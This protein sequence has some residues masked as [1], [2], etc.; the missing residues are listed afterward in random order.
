MRQ[1]AS[2]LAMALAMGL[3]AAALPWATNP[4]VAEPGASPLSAPARPARAKPATQP[5]AG[6]A[7]TAT[8]IRVE[9]NGAETRF[10]MDSDGEAQPTIFL[11]A[12]PPRVIIDIP[13]FEFRIPAAPGKAAPD[14]TAKERR[15][16]I[17]AFRYGL[18][19]PGQARIVI[20]V[21][22]P[23][24]VTR[25]EL[26]KPA[27]GQRIYT[28]TVGLMPTDDATFRSSVSEERAPPT[29]AD[30]RGEAKLKPGLAHELDVV[31]PPKSRPVIVIDAGHGGLDPGAVGVG[32]VLEKSIVLQVA[33]RLRATLAATRRYDVVMTRAT[34]IFVPLDQ[35]V[36]ISTAAAA[37]LF[38]SLHADSIGPVGE[39]IAV[40]G[41]TVYT[42]S[43]RASD[44]EARRLAEKENAVD[45]LAGV[46]AQEADE[47]DQVKDILIDLLRR[48]TANFSSDFRTMLVGELR[49]KIAMARDPNRSAAFK[50]LRQTRTP[51]V[52]IELGYMSHAQDQALMA[53]PEWQQMVAASIATSVDSYFSRRVVVGDKP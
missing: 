39:A 42:L 23:V 46:K 34:D 18:F 35:R 40:R 9:T 12:N 19:G 47:R 50:V 43:E 11:V 1:S 14:H 38:I 45:L 31:A 4:A 5:S 44:E 6:L 27:G 22:G 52:L 36:A 3:L 13:S 37:D 24:R 33:Q 26:L 32:G 21:N 25:A 29:A 48:E 41:A 10:Q 53:T 20:D 17:T 30:T 8:A 28:L 16:V 7:A 15:G 2:A 49:R 51:S